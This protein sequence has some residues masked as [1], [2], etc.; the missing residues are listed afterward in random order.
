MQAAPINKIALR[1]KRT[2]SGD[3]ATLVDVSRVTPL[4]VTF[5][6]QE[7][8]RIDLGDI[9]EATVVSEGEESVFRSVA[10]GAT[11]GGSL[12]TRFLTTSFDEQAPDRRTSQRWSLDSCW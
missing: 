11:E 1:V 5:R 10:V 4:G 8:N 3:A 6:P 9:V 2:D 7:S 12:V